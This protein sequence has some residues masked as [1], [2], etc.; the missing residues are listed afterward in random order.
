MRFII[1]TQHY[2]GLGFALRLRDEGHDVLIGHAYIEDRRLA[3]RHALLGEGLVERWPLDQLVENREQY[4][5]A[6]WVWD[7]NHS[8]VANEL[9]RAG[10]F[11]V[12]GGGQYP[13]T[14]EHDRDACLAFVGKY[15]LE[16]PPSHAFENPQ[17]ALAFLEEHPNLAFVFKPDYGETFETWLPQSTDAHE[18]G[19]ELRQHLR[20]LRSTSSFIL[21]ERKDGVEANV[22]VWFVEGQPKFAFMTIEAKKKLTADLGD[23]VG[24]AFDFAFAIPIE[25][26]AVTETVGKLFPAY[27]EMRYTGFGDANFIAARDGV[28]F[29]EKCERFGYNAHPNLFWTLNRKPLGETFAALVDGT[30][31]ADFSPG[32]GATCSLYMD[33]PMPGKALYF[34]DSLRDSLYFMDV[35]AE[36]DTLLTAGYN[37][38]VVI[39]T[40][41]GYTIPT[42]WEDVIAKAWQLRFPGRSFRVDG[43]GTDYPSSPLRRY[44]ALRAMGYI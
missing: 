22:E 21:Q 7:E 43:A 6:Y 26:R 42:A 24:C 34:P 32:F 40:G 19:L 29:F 31:E 11:K 30:F 25:S 23:L 12:L 2:S 20:T 35:Y 18:A 10:G 13:D 4:R 9:L 36:G 5:D 28:W 27:A 8:V 38:A 3:P 1:A 15:G 41:Y 14:M 16:A 44:E 33:H 39:A 17:A 37:D